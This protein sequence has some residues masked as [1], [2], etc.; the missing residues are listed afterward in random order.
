MSTKNDNS[1]APQ[2][3]ARMIVSRRALQ[4]GYE[5][6]IRFEATLSNV[7]ADDP[8]EGDKWLLHRCRKFIKGV[9][10]SFVVEDRY[11]AY[12]PQCDIYLSWQQVTNDEKHCLCDTKVEWHPADK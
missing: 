1:T 7:Y 12:C 9:S 6:M 2:H 8:T 10:S 4:A 5:A 11:V 3:D